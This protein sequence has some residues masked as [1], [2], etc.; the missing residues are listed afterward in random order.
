M[1][2]G[3][4]V[5]L[6]VSGEHRAHVRKE[7]VASLRNASV[8]G[9]YGT[10]ALRGVSLDLYPGE[11]LGVAGVDGNG[12]TE[13][14]EVLAGLRPLAEGEMCVDGRRVPAGDARQQMELGVFYV[15]AERKKR[16]AVMNLPLHVNAILK[17]HHAPPYSRKGILNH[18]AIRAFTEEQ[19][20]HYDIRCA[21]ID[22]AAGTLSGGN[23]QKLILAR[24]ISSGPRILVAEQPTR[25][26]D[27]GAIEYV[28]RLLLEQRE[29]GTAILLIS[30]DLD[31]ILALSDRIIVL[32][33]GK[34]AYECENKGVSRE[35]LGLAMGGALCA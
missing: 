24:E 16:G 2:V 35:T 8:V 26:L 17:S 31:E 29:K 33:A 19:T 34:V 25:G 23:L 13:L 7:A 4:D 32:Y 5:V 22:V 28:R 18:R 21:S 14:A 15:P 27:V 12:Q 6:R 10:Y 30:A 9:S 3:R 20:R 1:M 11:I